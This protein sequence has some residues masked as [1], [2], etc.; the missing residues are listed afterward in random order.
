MNKEAVLEELK[1]VNGI[2]DFFADLAENSFEF[3]D[4]SIPF[5]VTKD[6]ESFNSGVVTCL[7]QL[8]K[9]VK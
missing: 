1:K 6:K 3:L 8:R 4:E 2:D 5:Q 9:M 7:M